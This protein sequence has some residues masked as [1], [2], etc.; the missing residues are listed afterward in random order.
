MLLP[1]LCDTFHLWL[2]KQSFT[3]QTVRVLVGKNG[4]SFLGAPP[5]VP[6]RISPGI[7]SIFIYC[8]LKNYNENSIMKCLN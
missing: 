2:R 4:Q 3:L 6:P 1:I 7:V 8:F 5:L